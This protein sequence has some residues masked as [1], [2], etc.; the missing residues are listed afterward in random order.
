M[1]IIKDYRKVIFIIILP[2]FI[3]LFNI[4][5]I[6][7]IFRGDFNQN[8]S[9]IEVAFFTDAKFIFDHFPHLG[10]NPDWYL[11]FPFRLVYPPVLPFTIAF[12]HKIFGSVSFAHFYRILVGIFYA[13]IP[14]TLYFFVRYLTKRNFAALFAAFGYTILPS[15]SYLIE[16]PSGYAKLINGG[17]LRLVVLQTFGEGP[18]IVALSLIPL[19]CLLF[20][21]SLRNPSLKSK[22]LAA[23][24]I[25]SVAL[26]NWIGFV[27]LIIILFVLWLSEITRGEFGKKTKNVMTVLLIAYG[28]IAFWFTVSFIKSSLSFGSGGR[29]EGDI[30]KNYLKILPL[31]P[32]LIPL[33]V[34]ISWLVSKKVKKIQG[35]DFSIL[36]FLIFL[37]IITGWYSWGVAYLPQPPRYLPELDMGAIIILGIVL[38]FILR[39]ITNQKGEEKKPNRLRLIIGGIFILIVILTMFFFSRNYLKE[40]YD[41]LKPLSDIKTTYPYQI[42]EFLSE[43]I[44]KNERVLATANVSFWMDYFDDIQQV[45]GAADPAATHPWWGHALYQIT[46]GE[47]APLGEAGEMA[48]L[49]LKA[50]NANYIVVNSD[51]SQDPYHDYKDPEKFEGL[52]EEIYNF[53]GDIIYAVPLENPSL[54]QVV[55][56]SVYYQLQTPQN[57]V[58]YAGVKAY[59]DWV[60]D[61]TKPKATF[62]WINN[63]EFE[64]G[65]D[66]SGGELISVQ[67]TYDKGWQIKADGK[68]LKTRKDVIGNMVI[69]PKNFGKLSIKGEYRKTYDI[70]LGYFI[71]LTTIIVLTIYFIEEKKINAKVKY[72]KKKK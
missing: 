70:W 36:W 15:F 25:A 55:D 14:V 9:S 22:T 59:A 3:I 43:N 69:F 58:D 7:P 47:N 35:L 18:H 66:V 29:G 10:W 2:L 49:W 60:E 68:K 13:L 54:A 71:T 50:I 23:L 21:Y 34:A 63:D 52:F 39:K 45:K 30:L 1:E 33:L 11:G 57:A 31:L 16:G 61:G 46:S 6:Y 48:Y 28:L 53:N 12:L 17:P 32:V 44:D 41:L 37:F 24:G 27:S 20:L 40:P 42:T 19:A 8:I 62:N 38:D 65:A 72:S 67:M 56:E 64:I 51:Y 5:L 4:Y 26:V